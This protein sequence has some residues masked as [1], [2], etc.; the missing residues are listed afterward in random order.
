MKSLKLTCIILGVLSFILI[1]L[2]NGKLLSPQSGGI[3][4]YNENLT[5]L[6]VIL[7]MIPASITC[8]I[9]A[10]KLNR[11]PIIYGAL[12]L[13]A[14]YITCLVMPFLKPREESVTK[15]MTCSSCNN[16]VS[17]YSKPGHKCPH[18]GVIWD[19]EENLTRRGSDFSVFNRLF[20]W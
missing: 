13:F 18:C 9:I 10:W 2:L 6:F 15:T 8:A 14:P 16:V 7:I 12:G 1:I 17:A 19:R 4:H 3:R 11:S 20:R 5:N